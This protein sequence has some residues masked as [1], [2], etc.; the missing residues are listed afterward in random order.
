MYIIFK[1]NKLKKCCEDINLATK[2]W[3]LEIA[4]KI[5]QRLNEIQA[6]ECLSDLTTVPPTRFHPLEG[7]REGQ[8]A[9]DVKHP[10]R[11]IFCGVDG[12]DKKYNCSNKSKI[13]RVKILEV[14]DYHGK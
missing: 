4:K 9:V 5:I 10:F 2:E 6:A 11:L 12:N 8:Y 14:K 13:T 7:N 3:G 1:S